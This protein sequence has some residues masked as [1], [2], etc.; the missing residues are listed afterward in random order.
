MNTPV[1]TKE[2]MDSRDMPQTPVARRTSIAIDGPETRDQAGDNHQ[3][4]IGR[5]G[6][7]YGLPGH[8]MIGQWRG[9]HPGDE[10][11]AP[12]NFSPCHLARPGWKHRYADAAD[13]RDPTVNGHQQYGCK[14]NQCTTKQ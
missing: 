12:A 7:L 5:N 1:A 11:K 10:S 2:R 14:A 9:D 4:H 13:T 8:Q 3:R 6:L